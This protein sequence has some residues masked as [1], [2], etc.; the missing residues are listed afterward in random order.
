MGLCGR[1]GGKEGG[2]ETWH[3]REGG[4]G[5]RG[6]GTLSLSPAGVLTKGRCVRLSSINYTVA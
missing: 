3:R 5:E 4:R 6:R 2:K 1:D